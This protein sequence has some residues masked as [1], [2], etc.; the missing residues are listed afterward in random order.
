MRTDDF[1]RSLVTCL[2]EALNARD[3]VR[4]RSYLADDLHFVGMFGPPIDGPDA[5]IAAMA[6]LGAQQTTVKCL[7]EGD[8]VACQY[9]LALPSRPST[10]IFCCGWFTISDGRIKSLRVV[11]DPTPLGKTPDRVLDRT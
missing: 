9:Y 8:E 5:Y 6:R 2:A 11:F 7:V 10:P 3:L 1:E 4:A